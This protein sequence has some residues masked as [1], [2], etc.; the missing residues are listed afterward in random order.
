MTDPIFYIEQA[1]LIAILAAALYNLYLSN[2]NRKKALIMLERAQAIME[3]T[4]KAE[5]GLKDD[6]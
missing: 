3:R 5:A 6:N 4:C 2:I 1:A